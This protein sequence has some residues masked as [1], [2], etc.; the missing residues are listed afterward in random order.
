MLAI[1][2]DLSVN[3]VKGTKVLEQPTQLSEKPR[4]HSHVY[5]SDFYINMCCAFM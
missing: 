4:I 3:R 5:V 2:V 1:A